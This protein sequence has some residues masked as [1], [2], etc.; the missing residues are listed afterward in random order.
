M[1]FA[2]AVQQ[3]IWLSKFMNEINMPQDR[4]ITIFADNNGSIANTKNHK[5]HRQTKHIRVKYHF[6]KECVAAGDVNFTYVPTDE[7]LA[8]ILTKPLPSGAVAK[9]CNGIGLTSG[10]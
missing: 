10:A 2:R 4:P 7:N 6:T 8:D 5:N 1:A 9:C 3:A